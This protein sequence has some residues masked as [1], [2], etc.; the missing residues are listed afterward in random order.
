MS[1]ILEALRK[2]EREKPAP[3]RG[4]VVMTAAALGERPR[5][6]PWLWL[7]L[8]LAAGVAAAA[9]VL[10]WRRPPAPV[11]ASPSPA[12]VAAPTHAS[13][14]SPPVA[15]LS[16]APP[17]ASAFVPA[18]ASTL[19]AAP[20]IA[21]PPPAPPLVAATPVAPSPSPAATPGLVL[22]AITVQDGRPVALISDRLLREGD[23]IEGVRI[24]RI[25][26]AEVEIER[27][28]ER[29]FLRF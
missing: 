19:G 27:G 11:A 8:G 22:Q 17:L 20:A 28:G 9:A 23:E 2:L 25:G 29:S 10:E 21:P 16:P 3:E 4:V 26:E 18:P 14:P 5:R 7:S 15:S 12:S 1:L 13:V 6:G 24:V